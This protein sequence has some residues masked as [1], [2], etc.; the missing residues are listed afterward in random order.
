MH[1]VAEAAAVTFAVFV[2]ATACFA[3][4]CYGGE[5]GV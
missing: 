4:V 1:K 2:L 5:F 3:E